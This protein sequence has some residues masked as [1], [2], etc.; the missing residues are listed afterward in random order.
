MSTT[1]S[2]KSRV[3]FID[4]SDK[5][6]AVIGIQKDEYEV[7]AKFKE[8]GGAFNFRLK[9]GAGWIFSKRHLQE[10]KAALGVLDGDY[11]KRDQGGDM[12][13]AQNDQAADEWCRANL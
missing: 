13:D 1:L 5:S 6:F 7:H 2:T 8:I 12:L 4:Y 11:T 3:Q 9:C 10:V